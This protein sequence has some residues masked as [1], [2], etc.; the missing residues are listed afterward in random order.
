MV[1][2]QFFVFS[3]KKPNLKIKKLIMFICLLESS[4]GTGETREDRVARSTREMQSKMPPPYDLYEVRERL[5]LM[6]HTSSM[7][8]FLR[9]EIDRMQKVRSYSA[10]YAP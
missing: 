9:Q 8:I 4:S 2:L 1:I 10:F 3:F 7:N 5:R 6:G